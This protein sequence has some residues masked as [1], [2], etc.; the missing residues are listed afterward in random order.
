ML[1]LWRRLVNVYAQQLQATP[2]RTQIVTSAVLWGLGDVVAQRVSVDDV[3]PYNHTRTLYNAMY[4]GLFNGTVGHVWYQ[5]LDAVASAML[6]HRSRRVFLATKVAADSLLFG[7]VHVVAYFMTL[8]LVEHGGVWSVAVEKTKK[9]FFKTFAV[10]LAVWPAVQTVN[11][12]YVP[13]QYQLLVVNCVTVLDAAFMSWMQ[14]DATSK[15][16]Q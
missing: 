7:P 12:A 1:N 5:K 6:M 13:V 11:F 15:R 14:H 8:S 10:E 2:F 16:P 9:E 4:G 3:P